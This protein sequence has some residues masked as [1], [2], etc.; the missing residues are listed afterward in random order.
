MMLDIG[1]QVLWNNLIV[2][3]SLMSDAYLIIVNC[4]PVSVKERARV[5]FLCWSDG[6]LPT[7]SVRPD[8]LL[9]VPEPTALSV[10]VRDFRKCQLFSR[11]RAVENTCLVPK[12]HTRLWWAPALYVYEYENYRTFQKRMFMT[13]PYHFYISPLTSSL[14]AA[15]PVAMGDGVGA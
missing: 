1:A 13:M 9:P 7:A 6:S 14:L 15:M 2:N 12:S 11:P 3:Y 10:G 5:S 8:F 4:F